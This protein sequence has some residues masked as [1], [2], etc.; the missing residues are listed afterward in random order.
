[1]AG[2]DPRFSRPNSDDPRAAVCERCRGTGFELVDPEQGRSRVRRCACRLESRSGLRRQAASIPARY[3]H[4]R[5]TVFDALNPS[6]AQALNQAKRFVGRY[7][8]VDYGLMFSGPCGVGKTHLAVA[9][10]RELVEQTGAHGLFAEFNDLMRRIQAGFDKRSEQASWEVLG[11]V[12]D[13]DLLLLDDLGATRMTPWMQ[14]TLGLIINERYNANRTTLVTTNRTDA[15]VT[16]SSSL[17]ARIGERLSSRL[18]EMCLTVPMSSDDYRRKVKSAA[19][20][21]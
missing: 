19:Y 11:P 6:L 13:A 15:P 4:C 10:L 9:I 8:E 3:A 7:P 5:L 18:S 14:D 2:L 12:L 21:G 20:R 16:E 17:S 1:M